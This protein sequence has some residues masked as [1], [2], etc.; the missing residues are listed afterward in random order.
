MTPEMADLYNI[1]D[2]YEA[3]TLD[4]LR[5]KAGQVWTCHG[6]HT[7]GHAW[8]ME[9]EEP[10]ELCGR[11][12]GET[13]NPYTGHPWEEDDPHGPQCARRVVGAAECTCGK[14]DALAVR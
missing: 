7:A 5:E 2:D 9:G 1:A 12:K 11:R 8:T 3:D 6:P 4:H 10:C 14:A 13:L